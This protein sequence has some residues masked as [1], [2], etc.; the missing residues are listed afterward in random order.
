MSDLYWLANEQMAK[1]AAFFPKPHGK[2]RVDDRRVLSGIIFI[3]RNG[4][5]WRDA[6]EACG[7]HKTRCGTVKDLSHFRLRDDGSLGLIRE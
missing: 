3:D 1:L 2:P 5:R 4:L 6:P 7:P